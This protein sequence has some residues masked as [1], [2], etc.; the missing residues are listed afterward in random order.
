[1]RASFAGQAHPAVPRIQHV[2][3]ALALGIASLLGWARLLAPVDMDGADAMAVDA[4]A[5]ASLWLAMVAAMMLPTIEPMFATYLGVLRGGLAR[6]GLF[7]LA[8]L[9]PYLALWS[10]AGALA[11]V[12]RAIAMD[13]PLAIA[14]LLALAGAYQLGGTKDACLRACRSPFAFILQHGAG[15]GSLGAAVALG[16]RHTAVCLGCCAGLMLA[17]TAAGAMDPAWMALVGALLLGEKTLP[18]GA[19]LAR[20]SGI[21]LLAVAV[22]FAG[23]TLL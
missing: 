4:I 7:A 21:G 23:V 17:L 19:L 9:A 10:A 16:T 5:F 1:M 3:A 22:G 6:R 13:R 11:Y 12:V 15:T 20:A 14:A 2:V 8:F 18:H